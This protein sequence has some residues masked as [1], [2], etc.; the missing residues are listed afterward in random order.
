MKTTLLPVP[1]GVGL[2]MITASADVA[3]NERRTLAKI[4]GKIFMGGPF[5]S[6]AFGTPIPPHLAALVR[7]LET[8]R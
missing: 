5:P 6:D 4:R 3:T 1:D 7:Q 2:N 8:R